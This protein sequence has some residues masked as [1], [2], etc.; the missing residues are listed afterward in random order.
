MIKLGIGIAI[1]VAIM[2]FQ[3]APFVAELFVSSGAR[4]Q[5]VQV[6]QEIED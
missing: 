3:L 6:L 2:Q 5:I 1:G 4:D